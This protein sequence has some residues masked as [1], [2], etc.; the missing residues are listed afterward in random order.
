MLVPRDHSIALYVALTVR[1]PLS[2]VVLQYAHD[3]I[4]LPLSVDTHTV[5]LKSFA[6]KATLFVDG[7]SS[8][9]AGKDAKVYAMQVHRLERMPEDQPCGLGTDSPS[10]RGR[11]EDGDGIASPPVNLVEMVQAR[12][13]D[14]TALDLDNPAQR[15][16]L[17]LLVPAVNLLL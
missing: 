1:H 8:A 15:I 11:I 13:S 6:D 10:P 14:A 7:D 17:E 5:T 9:V 2:V 16:V 12:H 3:D 4:A